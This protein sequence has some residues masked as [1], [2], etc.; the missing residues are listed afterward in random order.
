MN[1]L[2][3]VVQGQAST[4]DVLGGLS[5]AVTAL[6]I[7]HENEV[8][9]QGGTVLAAASTLANSEARQDICNSVSGIC[10]NSTF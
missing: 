4:A 3:K 5:S 8:A 7:H 6:G 10:S 1:T 9:K 2:S